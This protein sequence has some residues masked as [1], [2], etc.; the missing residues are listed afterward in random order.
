V[1]L[2]IPIGL[3]IDVFVANG[4]AQA[5]SSAA[6]KARARTLCRAKFGRSRPTDE[7]S[8]APADK[9]A[10]Q[11]AGNLTA[12]RMAATAPLSSAVIHF[13]SFFPIKVIGRYSSPLCR[14]GVL[15]GIMRICPLRQSSDRARNTLNE[16]RGM[17]K[18]LKERCSPLMPTAGWTA[19]PRVRHEAHSD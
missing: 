18:W 7:P 10:G 1:N 17:H 13:G 6:K 8:G 5:Y 9:S 2:R 19:T 3:Q 16:L 12:L 14:C 11:T 4:A 15:N